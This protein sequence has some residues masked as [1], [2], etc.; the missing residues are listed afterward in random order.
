MS[1]SLP[2]VF[3]GLVTTAAVTHEISTLGPPTTS[4]THCVVHRVRPTPDEE[5]KTSRP[6]WG[7]RYEH[8]PSLSSTPV[9]VGRN[10]PEVL[11]NITGVGR[12]HS[13]TSDTLQSVEGLRDIDRYNRVIHC[14]SIRRT[15]V[16][17]LVPLFF[18]GLYGI[19]LN[20]R[21]FPRL[22]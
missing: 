15:N 19:Y 13:F 21:I 6:K 8:F 3:R 7:R 1:L 11:L 18:K 10:P 16:P 12:H 2:P 4:R 14:T 22:L 17:F 20:H 9:P 5:R